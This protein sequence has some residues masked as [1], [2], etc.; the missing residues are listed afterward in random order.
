MIIV[1]S[2]SLT[3]TI[4]HRWVNFFGISE[5]TMW[6][7]CT[8]FV[9]PVLSSF[10]T[11]SST[12]FWRHLFF[13]FFVLEHISLC[14]SNFLWVLLCFF[15]S[16]Q[17]FLT[18]IIVLWIIVSALSIGFLESGC[19]WGI[20]V[21]PLFLHYRFLSWLPYFCFLNLLYRNFQGWPADETKHLFILTDDINFSRGSAC[22]W[23]NHFSYGTHFSWTYD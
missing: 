2:T 12:I 16:C 15:I 14:F 1:F 23:F 3:Y 18:N 8:A 17:L 4:M 13:I 7:L 19:S 11:I 9:K 10:F 20:Y 21:F 22:Y 5:R 6:S